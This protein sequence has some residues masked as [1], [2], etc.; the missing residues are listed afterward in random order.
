MGKRERRIIYESDK[1][2]PA[3]VNIDPVLPCA[4]CGQPASAALA[5]VVYRVEDGQTE[6]KEVA[7]GEWL[8]KP[9]CGICA[10]GA[11]V[12]MIKS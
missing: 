8:I 10:E 9:M 7:T 5:S 12:Q 11:I 1:S 4:S 3:V 2:Y 6:Q